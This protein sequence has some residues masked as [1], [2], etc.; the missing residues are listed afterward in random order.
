M[1]LS[2]S[3]NRV[4]AGFCARQCSRDA[5]RFPRFQVLTRDAVVSFRGFRSLL[6]TAPLLHFLPGGRLIC[7]CHF[8]SNWFAPLQQLV[9]SMHIR[10]V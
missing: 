10:A 3:D 4:Q 1:S 9:C 8:P 7:T 6:E 5:V 2:G